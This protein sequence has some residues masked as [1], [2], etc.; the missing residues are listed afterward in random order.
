LKLS[1][2]NPLFTSLNSVTDSF[3]ETLALNDYIK[4][5]FK[6]GLPSESST[7]EFILADSVFFEELAKP[8]RKSKFIEA[9]SSVFPACKIAKTLVHRLVVCGCLSS[10][11]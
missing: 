7:W 9:I 4:V 10:F 2:G 1:T 11:N 8:L 5:N 3:V 6:L